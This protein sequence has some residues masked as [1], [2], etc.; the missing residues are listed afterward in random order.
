MPNK[1]RCFIWYSHFY[2]LIV[3]SSFTSRSMSIQSESDGV[4]LA[5]G[6][7]GQISTDNNC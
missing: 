5:A 7:R 4:D 1:A 2:P 6:R 3:A